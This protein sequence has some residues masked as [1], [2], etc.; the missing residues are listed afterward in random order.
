MA[1]PGRSREAVAE[2]ALMRDDQEIS[3]P[4]PAAS[5]RE[6]RRLRL[7]GWNRADLGPGP[8]REGLIEEAQEILLRGAENADRHR[9][10]L[11]RRSVSIPNDSQ[12]KM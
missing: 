6:V 2:G 10:L 7:P 4:G 8:A 12:G 5:Q 11:G 9:S 1:V 3:R